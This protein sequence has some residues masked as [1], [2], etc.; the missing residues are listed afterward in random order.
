[1]T[2]A[3]EP[4]A[5]AR[6]GKA[7]ARTGRSA[8]RHSAARLSAVQAL[9]QID[10]TGAEADGVVKE[11]LNH[12]LGVVDEDAA[13]PKSD[14]RLFA[15]LVAGVSARRA[16]LDA[17]LAPVM[18]EGWTVDRLEILLRCILRLGTY[19]LMARAQVPARVVI[20]EHVDLADAFFSGR[21]PGM[22]NGVLDRLARSLRPGEL[23]A[24]TG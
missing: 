22:V 12:R 4:K 2:R 23:E 10:L 3:A 19:E 24:K 21:E 20:S 8:G 7:R 15:E 13:I 1:M 11:F 17:Q 18:A 14:K 16:E 9:Y 6:T 5:R